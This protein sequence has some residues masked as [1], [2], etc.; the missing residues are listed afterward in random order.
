MYPHAQSLQQRPA[1]TVAPTA[2]PSL[3]VLKKGTSL[4]VAI[5]H[6]YPMKAGETIDAT[7]LYPVYINGQLAVP[8][9][10][11]VRGKVVELKS[12][13]RARLRGRLR[14]DFTPYHTA[15]VRFDVLNLASGP[16]QLDVDTATDGSPIVHFAAP[17]TSPHRGLVARQWGQFTGD[18]HQLRD[19]FTTPGR[20]DRVK[21]L[22]Y[23][24][25]PI[26]PERI[27]AHTAWTFELQ[28]PVTLPPVATASPAPATASTAGAFTVR[29]FLISALNSATTHPGD[30]VTATVVEPVYDTAGALLVPQGATL[31][32]KVTVAQPG[33]S[34]GRAG[35]LR[36]NFQRIEYPEG[37]I[38]S[39]EGTLSGAAVPETYALLLDA[40]GGATP[41]NQSSIIAPTVLTILAQR[42]MDYDDDAVTMQTGVASNGFGLAGRI[43]GMASGSRDLAAGIGFWAASLSIYDNFVSHGANVIFPRNTRIEIDT[44]TLHAPPLT[45]SQPQ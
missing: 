10:T 26:H 43:A 12:N 1:P 39:V 33:R 41:R 45:P 36:F 3:P 15:R 13:S 28:S 25:I 18:L 40:E 20:G 42:A 14:G 27:D 2:T 29:A 16:V 9:G 35:R 30:T 32:G 21:Q 8:Q 23:H 44:H 37:R 19:F 24:Q 38:Q 7:L 11:Q 6:A 22:I 4:Q 31:I 17:G 5:D 34:F